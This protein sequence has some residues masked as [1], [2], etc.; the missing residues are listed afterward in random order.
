MPITLPTDISAA[1]IAQTLDSLQV[2]PKIGL[3]SSEVAQRRHQF[4][5]NDVAEPKKHPIVRFLMK[6]SGVS[7]WML[8]IIVVLSLLLGKY[9]DCLLVGGL[10]IINAIIR[11]LQENRASDTVTL[12]QKKLHVRVRVRR[13]G[14]WRIMPARELVP[15][16]IIRVRPGDIIPADLKLLKGNL[17]VDQSSLTGESKQITKFVK[18]VLASG[19]IVRQG[20][21]NCVVTLTGANTFFGRTTELVNKAQPK[22]HVEEVIQKVVRWLMIIV[23]TLLV[24]V[25]LLAHQQGFTLIEI[26][27]LVLVLF[28]SAIPVA[29]PVMFT[30]S[31]A[32][33]AKNLAK[34]GVLVTQ[35]NAVED[36]ASMDILCVDKTGTITLNQLTIAEIIPFKSASEIDVLRAGALASN[37][38]NKDQI[39][40]A[41]INAAQSKNIFNNNHT[42][43][44]VQFIPF[45]GTNR[46]T[47]AR[48]EEDGQ[49]WRV[50]KGAANTLAEI[51]GLSAEAINSLQVRVDEFMT[52]GYR[53]LAVA[54]GIEPNPPELIGLVTLR[55]PPRHDAKHLI[56]KLKSIGISVKILTGDALP[57]AS[58]I[59]REVG[60]HKITRVTDLIASAPKP[61]DI[62]KDSDG[63][64]E[65]YPEDKFT[66]VK[67]LQTSNHITGMTGDGVN[68]A[69]ALR[70][71]EVGIAVKNAADVAKSAASIVLTQS[72]LN[73]IV[74]LIT[75]GRMIYQRILTWIINKISR[76]LFKSAFVAIAFFITGKFVISAF[77]MLLITFMSDFAK[78]ALATDHVRASTQPETWNITNYINVGIVLGI[79]MLIESL[80]LLWGCWHPLDLAHQQDT[81]TSFSY[82][83]LLYFGVFSVISARERSWFWASRPSKIF[84]I[85]LIATIFIG[86]AITYLGLPQLTPLPWWQTLMILVYTMTFCLTV[87]DAIKV[88]MLTWK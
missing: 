64:A 6:F 12:L 17:S 84:L 20:E 1:S 44:R 30:A 58:E 68:D 37:E 62:F 81:L 24:M 53:V 72:G 19:S 74:T 7:A 57:I 48:V 29:L 71:A 88:A 69:P 32:V 63:F 34:G 73:S 40:M 38:A 33:G 22:L 2:D 21:G 66:V 27:P 16:D 8:E 13:D 3:T 76:T 61:T 75:E 70:Q 52:K 42:F 87:N 83:L 35:L 15:G 9:G 23:C 55:D 78:I 85:S 25:I 31:M 45:D 26:A 79:L 77:A 41:F 54:Q 47:E 80:L 46:R 36:A 50:M 43:N 28:M 39:D 60:L 11:F 49:T 14:K 56:S 59:A 65:V 82:L 67:H 86:T 10:L 4:G 51:C 18:D 5:F